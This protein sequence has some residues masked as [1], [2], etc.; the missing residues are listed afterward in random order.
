MELLWVF[1]V[2][3]KTHLHIQS[4]EVLVS[5]NRE[6]LFCRFFHMAEYHTRHVDIDVDG[7]TLRAVVFPDV[8]RDVEDR[9]L[10]VHYARSMKPTTVDT[11]YSRWLNMVGNTLGRGKLEPVKGIVDVAV[12]DV[13]DDDSDYLNHYAVAAIYKALAL[14]AI[15]KSTNVRS[16]HLRHTTFQACD[17][18]PAYP[19]IMALIS[20][21]PEL[22]ITK[23]MS[24]EV[25]KHV[26]NAF[27]IK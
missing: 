12:V 4:I 23:Y 11:I 21:D 24:D 27:K 19:M 17:L 26:L 8:A 16:F 22:D 5:D 6:V 3:R 18:E 13:R 15:E 2:V 14:K 1:V 20:S 10:D 9:L 25:V 7:K